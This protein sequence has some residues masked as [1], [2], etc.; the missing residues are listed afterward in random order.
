M[1]GDERSLGRNDRPVAL[2]PRTTGPQCD[3]TRID[4]ERR[5]NAHAW[6]PARFMV[7]AAHPDDADFGPAAT[8][9]RW[10]DA[11][12]GRLARLLHERRRRR[13]G[14]RR[15]SA[16]AGRRC[17]SG[18]S[19]PRPTI[20]GY[21]GV[22]FLHQPD[23]ALAN[24]LALREQLV[25]EIRTFRPDAVLA[26]DPTVIFY[27]DGGVNHTDHRAAGLAAVDA[28]YPAAR[29]PMA[30]PWLARSGLAA[31]EVRRLYLFWPNEPNVRVDITRRS[32]AR[33]RRS[34]RTPARSRSPPSSTSGSASGRAEEGEPI[35]VAAG[36][37]LRVIV[38]DDDEDEGPSTRRPSRDGPAASRPAR[39]A[40]RGQLARRA[41]PAGR[42]PTRSRAR[43]GRRRAGRAARRARRA[44]GPPAASA[45]VLV[46]RDPVRSGAGPASPA[47]SASAGSASGR[48][49]RSRRRATGRA[50]SGRVRRPSRRTRRSG[51]PSEARPPAMSRFW[52]WVNGPQNEVIG[53]EVE[54]RRLDRPGDQRFERARRAGPA[55]AGG[56]PRRRRR[57][58]RRPGASTS[59]SPRRSRMI[60]A[61]SPGPRAHRRRERDPSSGSASAASEPAGIGLGRARRGATGG[62]DRARASWQSATASRAATQASS[63]RLGRDPGRVRLD[64]QAL[65][66]RARAPRRPRRWRSA[67][68]AASRVSWLIRLISASQS[69]AAASTSSRVCRPDASVAE[70]LLGRLLRRPDGARIGGRRLGLGAAD[71][72]VVGALARPQRLDRRLRRPRGLASRPRIARRRPVAARRTRR[73]ARRPRT[74]GRGS[75]S[76]A[77]AV[78]RRRLGLAAVGSAASGDRA[79]EPD[80]T[81][82]A[83]R[84]PSSVPAR[85]AS[86][87]AAVAA[88]RRPEGR[89]HRVR[90][91][92]DRDPDRTARRQRDRASG[93]A[94]G[95]D[96]K[97]RHRRAQK[98]RAFGSA[99]R[100]GGRRQRPRH[101]RGRRDRSAAGPGDCGRR[102]RAGS[103][104]G[105][106]SRSTQRRSAGPP[107][108]GPAARLEL[109]FGE[110][111]RPSRDRV[112]GD[113]DADFAA[114]R[115]P[116][117]EDLDQ[118][119]AG[120]RRRAPA[121]APGRRTRSR[122]RSAVLLGR[123]D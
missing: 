84:S 39:P 9:A 1:G 113:R 54:R 62:R 59:R 64:R 11:G 81:A 95:G 103:S 47:R 88:A 104:S 30:F 90:L 107:R 63:A 70:R 4:D 44:S 29:N 7:I 19:A 38:I 28:V 98:E 80:A 79:G 122:S 116:G 15:R 41:G 66:R 74:A 34:R 72:V 26:T 109:G 25:R 17:A 76:A 56:R 106:R 40:R 75:A 36:E 115:G 112:R 93:R 27:R 57:A 69:R 22:T 23:G 105:G 50:G 51:N 31:H 117:P 101:R 99:D 100:M 35:G 2:Q 92:R 24:D 60:A 111:G 13:R 102:R 33:S 16:R 85:G 48:G 96:P 61:S 12:L 65:E 97:G 42:C 43:S 55:S 77:L 5:D 110:R 83:R 32:T 20:I 58:G 46:G 123:L 10:I 89:D 21:A 37:A 45:D 121:R 53:R 49:R 118:R 6:R 78:R 67:A 108:A 114:S 3:G 86:P 18:S 52:D 94:R 119:G 14:S 73:P 82:V 87:R 91:A 8:A 68:A 120:S 71:E